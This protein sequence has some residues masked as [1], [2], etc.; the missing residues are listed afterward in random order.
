M[1]Q[2][3]FSQAARILHGGGVI[4]YPTEA[5][6]GLGCD[7]YNEKAV[8]RLLV[9]KKRPVNKGVILV[10]AS[11]LQI[12]PLLN[13]L[14][15]ESLARLK[16]SWPGPN[17]WLIP[18][19]TNIIPSWIKGQHTSVAIRV[20]AHPGIVA[21]CNAFNGPVVST[22]ANLSGTDPA[23]TLLRVSTYFGHGLDYYLPGSLGD[24]AQPTRIQDLRDSR[25][26]RS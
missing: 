18:D 17:T 20:S 23:K 5:V 19:P 26:V 8:Q 2:W 10:A 14:D 1:N 24:S 12:Q 16:S 7:P 9:L 4:A 21:M 6:W 22:S 25:V 13:H 3:H 11:M 15:N